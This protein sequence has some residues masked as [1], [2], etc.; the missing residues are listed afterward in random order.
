[1]LLIGKGVHQNCGW[2]ADSW[3]F[4]WHLSHER[5]RNVKSLSYLT[6]KSEIPRPSSEPAIQISSLAFGGIPA[7]QCSAATCWMRG[8]WTA[9]GKSNKAKEQSWLS[10]LP[11]RWPPLPATKETSLQITQIWFQQVC[12]SVAN[13]GGGAPAQGACWLMRKKELEDCKHSG[14]GRTIKGQRVDVSVI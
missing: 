12:S 2:T 3:R 14:N 1:M 11:R 7:A 4:C 10:S 6:S 13:V 8:R 9:G 5:L